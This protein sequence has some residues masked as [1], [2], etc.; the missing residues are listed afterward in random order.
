M[1][2]I[3]RSIYA[4]FMAL[5]LLTAPYSV[6]AD[7]CDD[8]GCDLKTDFCDS[9]CAYENCMRAPYISPCYALTF[10]VTVGVITLLVVNGSSHSH[11]SHS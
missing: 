4:S 9:G 2:K 11:S 6:F 7:N 5:A 1:K 3:S 8:D 10:V